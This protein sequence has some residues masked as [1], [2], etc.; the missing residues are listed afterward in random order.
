MYLI[1]KHRKEFGIAQYNAECIGVVLVNYSCD[2]NEIYEV[3]EDGEDGDK[4]R[5]S[6]GESGYIG[7]IQN[8]N[9]IL[10]HID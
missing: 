5:V 7:M 8:K 4:Y 6:F 2:V 9:Y 10:A 1:Y 3:I